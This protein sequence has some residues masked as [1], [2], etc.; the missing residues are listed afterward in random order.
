MRRPRPRRRRCRRGPS[1]TASARREA[2]GP[3]SAGDAERPDGAEEQL[4][5]AA[6][7]EQAGPGRARRRPG[8]RGGAAPARRSVSPIAVGVAERRGPHRL[9]TRR[10]GSAPLRDHRNG[11]DRMTTAA[12]SPQRTPRCAGRTAAPVPASG[13]RP[14]GGAGGVVGDGCVLDAGAARASVVMPLVMPRLRGASGGRSPGGRSSRGSTMP[15]TSPSWSTTMR[16]DSANSSSRSSEISST[17]AP[18]ARRSSSSS[19][20]ARTEAMSRPRLG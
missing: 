9:E 10:P 14:S 18:A 8:R 5:L 12:E 6:D 13:R 4:A 2:A 16:S 17:P 1:S 19:W 7:V 3:M 15:A 11:E 20:V